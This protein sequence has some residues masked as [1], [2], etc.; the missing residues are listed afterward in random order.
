MPANDGEDVLEQSLMFAFIFVPGI[1][2]SLEVIR[3]L[4]PLIKLGSR[5][6]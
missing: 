4:S 3:K 6:L 2:V 1:A 5:Q